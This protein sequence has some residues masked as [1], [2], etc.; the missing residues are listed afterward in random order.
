M[1]FCIIQSVRYLV[2]KLL[3]L[4]FPCIFLYSFIPILILVFY[5]YV[6][7]CPSSRFSNGRL[8]IQLCTFFLSYLR[9][10]PQ[11][12]D[13]L[14]STLTLF[15]PL[16]FQLFQTS[17]NL[18][19]RRLGSQVPPKSCFTKRHILIKY[20]AFYGILLFCSFNYFFRSTQF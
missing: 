18:Q 19:T 8:G 11:D 3:S 14:Y 16:I 4:L 15:S 13:K 12:I 9:D 2:T 10:L 20:T 7:L 5:L 1:F 6:L 17:F